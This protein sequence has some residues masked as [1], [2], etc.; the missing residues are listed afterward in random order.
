MVFFNLDPAAR[1]FGRTVSAEVRAG[2]TQREVLYVTC[3]SDPGRPVDGN[4]RKCD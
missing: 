4:L 2:Q 3:D 1:R